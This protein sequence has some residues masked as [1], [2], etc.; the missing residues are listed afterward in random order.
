LN[1]SN[2]KESDEM[3]DI[4]MEIGIKILYMIVV[5]QTF[6]KLM[7]LIRIYP[8]VGFTIRLLSKVLSDLQ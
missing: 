3:I 4:R 7:F 6:V 1:A 2:A 5:V 8:A